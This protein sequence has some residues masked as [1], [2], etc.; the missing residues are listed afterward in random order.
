M[1]ACVGPGSPSVRPLG[2]RRPHLCPKRLPTRLSKKTR[3]KRQFTSRRGLN[4]PGTSLASLAPWGLVLR[5]LRR[6][7]RFPGLLHRGQA[8][9]SS[10]TPVHRRTRDGR[11]TDSVSS[12]AK[13]HFASAPRRPDFTIHGRPVACTARPTDRLTGRRLLRRI[14]LHSSAV[15]IRWAVRIAPKPARAN[16][17]HHTG[18]AIGFEELLDRRPGS[19]SSH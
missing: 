13:C 18:E 5:G 3:K 19:G 16:L 11:T 2:P 10:R 17:L 12:A 8:A 4:S 9:R 6:G 14:L 1:G 15:E 7:G